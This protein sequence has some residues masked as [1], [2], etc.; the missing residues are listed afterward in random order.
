MC[1]PPS[2]PLRVRSTLQSDGSGQVLCTDANQASSTTR[3]DCRCEFG[4]RA[5]AELSPFERLADGAPPAFLRNGDGG[6]ELASVSASMAWR[7][8]AAAPA[9]AAV[10][11]A[12]A[13]AWI[14]SSSARS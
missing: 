5:L 1:G 8:A 14:A 10:A 13:A 4:A 9:A 7:A 12:A 3:D 2:P 11:A 6:F